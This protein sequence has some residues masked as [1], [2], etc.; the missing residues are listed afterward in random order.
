MKYYRTW[1]NIF[2][3]SDK[4][5]YR[6]EVYRKRVYRV[7]VYDKHVNRVVVYGKHVYCSAR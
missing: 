7:V 1:F 2:L 6:V 5:V 3:F 4:H